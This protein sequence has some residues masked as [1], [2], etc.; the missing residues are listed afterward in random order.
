MKSNRFYTILIVPEKTA[1]I[2]K[3][4]CPIW[5]IRSLSIAVAFIVI[6]FGIM[7]FDYTY[8]MNQIGENKHLKTE[9][10]QLR[11]QIQIFENKIVAIETTM[12]RVKSFATRLKVIMHLEDQGTN[13]QGKFSTPNSYHSKTEKLVSTPTSTLE[14]QANNDQDKV[15]PLEKKIFELSQKALSVEET[16][17]DEYEILHNKKAF[18]AALPTSKPASGYFTSGFGI[19]KSPYGDRIKMHE[20][21]DISNRLGTPIYSP[22]DGEVIFSDSKTGYGLT[23]ILN[24]G[25]GIETWYGHLKQFLV[26]RGERIKRGK[27]IALLGNSGRA[28][29]PHVHYEVHVNGYPVD[30]ISFIFENSTTFH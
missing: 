13:M 29:G 4:I 5:V 27:K 21:L 18:L 9:N 20:G 2:K 17:Q 22:A 23:L 28:T 8:V 7:I 10:K 6:L 25:Y 11:Q 16:L 14:F 26:S 15:S 24:H 30:P 12:E 3:I 19:R 1:G